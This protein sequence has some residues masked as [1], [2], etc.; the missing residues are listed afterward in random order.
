MT[1]TK[2]DY[3]DYANQIAIKEGLDPAIFIAQLNQE[4]GFNPK[5]KTPNQVQ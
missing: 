2:R 3:I 4:S 5:A 1:L